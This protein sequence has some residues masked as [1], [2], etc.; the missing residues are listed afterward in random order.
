MKN[1]LKCHIPWGAIDI[2]V[3]RFFCDH[4]H[5]RFENNTLVCNKCGIAWPLSKCFTEA[6]GVYARIEQ[7]LE[8]DDKLTQLIKLAEQYQN[9]TNYLR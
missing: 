6:T 8:Q 3:S 9:D 1:T 2:F 5:T 7:R 4:L